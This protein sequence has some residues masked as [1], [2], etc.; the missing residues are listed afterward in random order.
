MITLR[1]G[2]RHTSPT[3]SNR[4]PYQTVDP[5]R[6]AGSGGSDITGASKPSK[7]NF[8]SGSLS[9]KGSMSGKSG[10]E[11]VQLESLGKGRSGG[12]PR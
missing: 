12:E 3:H 10:V 7:G 8:G 9:G 11:E 1:S 4:S 2:S 5:T 6:P